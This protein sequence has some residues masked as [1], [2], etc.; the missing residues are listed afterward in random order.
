M[1]GS[2]DLIFT[3]LGIDKGSE[4]FDK[5]G[6][7]AD[8]FGDKLSKASRI[9]VTAMGAMPLAAAAAGVATAGSLALV[10]LGVIGLSAVILQN[11]EQ[12]A[13]DY[14]ALFQGIVTG[15]KSA[16]QP[17]AKDLT[18]AANQMR[19]AVAEIAPQFDQLFGAAGPGVES[20]TRGIVGFTK[21]AMPGFVTAVKTSGPAL[22]GLA[23]L[24][25]STGTGITQFFTNISAGSAS[26]GQVMDST[27]RIIRDLLGFAGKLFAQLSNT[28]SPAVL[29]LESALRQAEGAILSLG[30]GAFPVLTNAASGFLTAGSGVLR[31]LQLISPVIGPL[32]GEAASF[33]TSLKLVDMVSFG[34]VSAGLAGV[35]T[36]VGEAEGAGG[37]LKAGFGALATGPLPL[38]GIA[39][40]GLSLLLDNL[41]KK[42]RE[43]AEA[44]QFHAGVVRE[45]AGTL[46]KTSGGI[47]DETR[48][49]IA[50]KIAKENVG[51]ASTTMADQ[52]MHLGIA[53]RTVAD[54]V[55]NTNGAMGRMDGS[56]RAMTENQIRATLTSEQLQQIHELTGKSVQDLG[57]IYM[58]G[59][60]GV[61]AFQGQLTSLEQTEGAGTAGLH[62]LGTKMQG[63]TLD[64]RNLWG[65]ITELNHGLTDAQKQAL[66]AALGMALLTPA[67]K[68]A[69]IEA[70]KLKTA[71]TTLGDSMK[72]VAEKGAAILLILDKMAGKSPDLREATQAWDDLMRSMDKQTDWDSAA[73][74]VQKLHKGLVDMR[75]E[76]DTTT[77][78]GSKLQNWAQ[79]SATDF[80]NAAEA[81]KSAGVPADEMIR[82]LGAMR[83]QFIDNAIAQ[84][85]PQEEAKRLADAWHLVPGEVSTLVLTPNLAQK[86]QEMGLF[87]QEI[88][89]L[90]DGSIVVTANDG[91][92]RSTITK[93]IQDSN[94]RVITLHVNTVSGVTLDTTGGVWAA[95]RARGG[96]VHGP[97]TTTS[98]SIPTMLSNKEFVVNAA[99]AERYASTLEAINAGRAPAILAASGQ[100]TTTVSGGG[101]HYHLTVVE[102]ANSRVDLQKQ[103]RAMELMSG[104][105]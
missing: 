70:G 43:A 4:A 22:D 103:F 42:Q 17:M 45:L 7:S 23:S 86:M 2:R 48:A 87:A 58:G 92:A 54:A 90:P 44:A 98:D 21:N 33:A 59:A 61:E 50:N 75:G 35:K 73:K 62:E 69:Q 101:N 39:A 65:G 71:Y 53:Q 66:Q 29:A 24:M 99:D 51:K 10:G 64:S 6:E 38:L 5:A 104:V 85:L 37:K 74:G 13:A 78:A 105:V 41:G 76:V 89:Q 60:G 81:M 40:I 68:E 47:T 49:F 16:A 52:A 26:S 3:I 14:G 27:G 11:N 80:A 19:F 20:L 57:T 32:I 93:L 88:R 46:D 95:T 91:Q 83:Q 31:L 1:S 8:K 79:Q 67:E 18:L 30:S 84:K 55:L 25:S 9:G 56:L 94:G 96:W 77:E 34:G 63:A 100:T 36:A 97:G 28:G 102:A 82:K 72:S 12:V 15:A